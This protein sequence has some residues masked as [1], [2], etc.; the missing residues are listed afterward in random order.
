MTRDMVFNFSAGPSMLPEEVMLKAA[1]EITNF[2]GTGMSV[3]E[4]SHRGKYF[5]EIFDDT[6]Q[7]FKDMLAVPDSHDILFL[8]GGA[9]GQL[10]AVPMN[11][12]NVGRKADYAVTGQF[13]ALA[14]KEAGKY[15]EIRIAADTSDTGHTAIP[16]QDELNIES[17]ASYFYYCDNNTVYG[18]EWKYIPEAGGIPIVSD[19]SSN[20]LSKPLDISKYGVIFA[21]AQKNLTPAG[22]TVV[23]VEKAL[24][25][26]EMSV[27]P[28]ILS[29]KRMID[30]N[31]MI[32][33]P[34]CF[35]IYMLGLMLDWINAKGG[36]A[37]ME[38]NKRE[39]SELLYGYLDES[40]MFKGSAQKPFRSHMNVTFK[41]GDKELDSEFVKG[42]EARGLVSLK[43][44]RAAGGMRASLY[45][46][47]PVEGV[48]ALVNYMKEFEMKHN[49]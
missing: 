28:G 34:P 20:I 44:H 36:I 3:M 39:R 29:Y 24:A 21:G 13:S 31:S 33:T 30:G 19:M 27:T 45:N 2:N 22:L 43:G 37:G 49:V 38:K 35:N 6:K 4:M 23:I 18:T 32:N 17:G 12:L 9:T 25:G 40:R 15:G 41:T 14:A 5:Q 10:A 42:A 1:S 47:M 26:N 16:S 7:K 8:Q 11:L 48:A 46:A